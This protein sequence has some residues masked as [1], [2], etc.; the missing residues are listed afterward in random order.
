MRRTKSL[1]WAAGGVLACLV[2]CGG[3]P[4]RDLQLGARPIEGWRFARNVE[5]YEGDD[6]G[7]VLAGDA[8]EY[9]S[10]GVERAFLGRLARGDA[11][12]EVCA[13]ECRSSAA[14]FG[15]FTVLR[16][17]AGTGTQ[18][19][20]GA[21]AVLGNDAVRAWK[22][23]YVLIVKNAQNLEGDALALLA[24]TLLAPIEEP[25]VKPLLAR[26]LPEEGLVA[27][28]E[29]VFRSRRTLALAWRMDDI[30][31]FELGEPGGGVPVAEGVYAQYMFDRVDA[32]LF[33]ARYG[34]AALAAAVEKAIVERMRKGAEI[35]RNTEQFHEVKRPDG[36]TTL[37][38]RRGALLIVV[39]ST[40]APTAAKRVVGE[41]LTG[42]EQAE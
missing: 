4:E 16:A 11:E 8:K 7:L 5:R 35:Y 23:R 24:D 15:A 39:P 3:V 25:S 36:G 2:G 20:A 32:S 29:V 31:M 17:R 13:L 26:A 10:L 27:G 34:D 18:V 21:A 19:A 38:R 22:G 41:L 9:A 40:R 42:L 33:V 6:L 37:A 1:P 30:D 12:V 14:A 28:S